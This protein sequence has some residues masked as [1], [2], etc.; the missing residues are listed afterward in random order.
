MSFIWNLKKTK[1]VLRVNVF[2]KERLKENLINSEKQ[3]TTKELLEKIVF[4]LLY[5]ILI[6]SINDRL[7]DL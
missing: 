3:E 2:Y 7:I 5:P 6:S 1:S 4:N